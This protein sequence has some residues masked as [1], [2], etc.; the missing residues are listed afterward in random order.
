[1]KH[2][3]VCPQWPLVPH[4]GVSSAAPLGRDTVT[5]QPHTSKAFLLRSPNAPLR[6]ARPFD[7]GWGG[8]ARAAPADPPH[9]R[10]CAQLTTLRKSGSVS[11]SHVRGCMQMCRQSLN[12]PPLAGE[13]HWR[14]VWCR[15]C[16]GRSSAASGSSCTRGLPA[17]PV[18]SERACSQAASRSF[19]QSGRPAK[20]CPSCPQRHPSHGP[21]CAFWRSTRLCSRRSSAGS[22]CA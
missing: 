11:T 20:D 19:R 18:C 5:S 14:R 10:S 4:V 6:F 3:S 1:M 13:S 15:S 12:C 21:P 7:F 22:R 16:I 2:N 8:S 9:P 17:P